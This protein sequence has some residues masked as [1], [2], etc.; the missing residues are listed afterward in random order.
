MSVAIIVQID[1]VKSV[2]TSL[3]FYAMVSVC[4]TSMKISYAIMIA[5]VRIL[6]KD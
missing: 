3:H 4:V 1:G 2:G 6:R 5:R